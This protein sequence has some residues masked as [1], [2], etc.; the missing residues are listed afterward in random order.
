MANRI[1]RG[2]VRIGTVTR[3]EVGYSTRTAA[4]AR[5]SGNAQTQVRDDDLD[6]YGH[7]FND[8][9][10]DVADIDAAA[11]AYV[12]SNSQTRQ[13]EIADSMCKTVVCVRRQVNC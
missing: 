6:Q 13:C 1:E 10:N 9:L 8:R 3:L 2:L 5:S 4:Q 11:D 12:V 7:L